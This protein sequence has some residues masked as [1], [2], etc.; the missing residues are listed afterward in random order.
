MSWPLFVSTYKRSFRLF[1]IFAILLTFYMLTTVG[2]YTG[3]ESDPFESLPEAMK[4]AFGMN[5]GMNDLTGFLAS[6]FYGATFVMF[7]M[8]YCVI[9]TNQLIAHLVDRGS[10]AYLLSTPVSRRRIALTQASVLIVN[11]IVIVLLMTIVGLILSPSLVEGAELNTSAFLRINLMGFLVFFVISGYSFLFSCLLNEVKR[12]LAASGLLSVLFYG[13]QMVANMGGE[14]VGWLRN[15][16]V[17]TTFQP[18][19]IAE[20]TYDVVTIAL[21]L[22]LS[23]AA[24]YG[25]AIWIFSRR[26]LPL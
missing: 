7:L 16:T 18:V 24:L 9:V 25:I 8:I 14:E 12:T 26:D 22:G 1:I 5:A 20:G 21:L 10:M 23:G 19:R 2:M 3:G 13:I 6:G 11:L 17:L 4:N 15:F